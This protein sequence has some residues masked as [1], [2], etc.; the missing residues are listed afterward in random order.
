MYSHPDFGVADY[1]VFW[2]VGDDIISLGIGIFYAFSGGR[3]RTAT[4]YLCRQPSNAR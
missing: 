1:C 2:S 3:Q 4:E